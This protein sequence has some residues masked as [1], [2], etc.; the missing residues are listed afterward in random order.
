MRWWTFPCEALWLLERRITYVVSQ[1]HPSALF[2]CCRW[3]VRSPVPAAEGRETA[4]GLSYIHLW[5][6]HKIPHPQHFKIH[7]FHPINRETRP[8]WKPSNNMHI[9]VCIYSW[10]YL[11]VQICTPLL[12]FWLH[13]L[14]FVF[15]PKKSLLLVIHYVFHKVLQ[16]SNQYSVLKSSCL[17]WR[18]STGF[19]F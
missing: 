2:Q 9:S 10:I 11:E 13:I 3:P 6:T 19:F 8:P 1:M 14:W 17:F 7:S 4:L 12:S 18:H 16:I 15:L 5:G